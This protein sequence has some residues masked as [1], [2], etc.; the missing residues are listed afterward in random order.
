VE[1]RRTDNSN[2]LA[3]AMW[4]GYSVSPSHALVESL[5]RPHRVV[6]R[7]TNIILK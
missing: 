1:P 4:D 6:P 7:R 3:F 5:R 2:E